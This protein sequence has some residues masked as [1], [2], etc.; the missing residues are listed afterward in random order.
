MHDSARTGEIWCRA[1]RL[2][3]LPR[4]AGVYAWYGVPNPGPADYAIE[5]SQQE[6]D[7]ADDRF[8]ALLRR[9]SERLRP[10]DISL[11]GTGGFSRSWLGALEDQGLREVVTAERS[12]TDQLPSGLREAMNS[13]EGRAFLAWGVSSTAPTLAAPVY[14]GVTESL[15]ARI[16]N[17]MWWLERSLT[18]IRHS[19][20][21]PESWLSNFGARAA[22][23]GFNRAT[24]YLGM[25]E[26]QPST[27]QQS[28]RQWCEGLEWLLNRWYRPILGRA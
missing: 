24:L 12:S 7:G 11:T 26:A 23:A 28:L 3:Q 8:L 21:V 14:I 5:D 17:H 18:A 10:A 19:G 27:N 4:T 16:P 1:D 13:S 15:A 2:P 25:V 22:Q 20:D 9:H 6:P